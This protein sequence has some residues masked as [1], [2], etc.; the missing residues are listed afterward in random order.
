MKSVSDYKSL[1]S[2]RSDCKSDRTLLLLIFFFFLSA[3]AQDYERVRREWLDSLRTATAEVMRDSII[4][5]D[6]DSMK[7]WWTVYGE[8]PT[9]GRSLWISLHGGGGTTP[10][11]NDQQWRNQMRLYRPQE[12]VYVAPRSPL[13]AWDMWCQQPIDS[14]YRVLIRTMIAHY[15]VNPDKVY[16]LGY[17]AGG[18]GVWRMAPRMADHWAAASMM[19]GHPGDVRLENLLNTPFMIW[20][21]AN[22]E[23][24]NR[25]KLD[26]ERGVQMDSLQRTCPDG[27]VHETHIMEGKGHWMD[28]EDAAALPWMAQ[29]KRNAWPKHIIWQQEAVLRPDFYWLSAPRN[30]L[31]RGKRVDAEVKDN[32]I[33]IAC[34]DYSSLTLYL[35]DELVNLKKPVTIKLRGKKVFSGK[36]K[37]NEEVYRQTLHQRQ[38]HRFASPYRIT[39]NDK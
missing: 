19:A 15:D 13:E 3:F 27:Y 24:Y 6:G 25:N 33:D 7:L 31:K 18:D 9:D 28:R 1:Y 2:L 21:G 23:A 14:M 34:C 37:P 30:E 36:L 39:I 10:E 22:D 4:R 20:C 26:R 17:S 38:D 35:S 8:K 5:Q 16:L 11:V 29:Y 32:T 12:G